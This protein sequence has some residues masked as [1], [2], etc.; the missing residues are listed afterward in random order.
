[1]LDRMYAICG[2]PCGK[3]TG[4]VSVCV[5]VCVCQTTQVFT[6]VFSRE[7]H[8]IRAD[9]RH[10]GTY[11][12][13]GLLMRGAAANISD[14]NRNIARLRPSLRMAH[15]NTEVSGHTCVCVGKCAHTRLYPR[16]H[17]IPVQQLVDIAA[18][19]GTWG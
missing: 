13:C 4:F 17:S 9:P 7:H 8:L 3:F 15:W 12:A 16:L 10:Q 1:M 5:C 18:Y 6:D 14:I 19:A 2:A 11:L